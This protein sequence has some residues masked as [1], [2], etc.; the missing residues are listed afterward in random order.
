MVARPIFLNKIIKIVF[1]VSNSHN[2]L[3]D[4][5]WDLDKAPIF[6]HIDSF[7][8]RC[9]DMIEVCESMIVFGRYNETENILKPRFGGSRGV[10]FE[11]WAE[12]ME[13]MFNDSLAD[14]EKV[15]I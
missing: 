1:K 13:K 7:I 15:K 5:P 9:K 10:E 14:I 4:I 3:G 12:R 8:Q 6:N 11:Q 2:E